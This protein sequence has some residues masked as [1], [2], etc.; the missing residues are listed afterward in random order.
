VDVGALVDA[1]L[2]LS[3]FDLFHGLA[4]FGG[5]GSGF[6]VRH[7]AS[8]SEDPTELADHPHHVGS[9]DD[10]VEVEEVL[11][12]DAVG[13]VLSAHDVGAGLLRLLRGFTGCERGDADALA[14]AV[15][16]RDRAPDH[17]VGLSRI[18][19]EP[20][21]HVDGFV[22]LALGG[23]FDQRDGFRRRIDL[24]ALDGLGCFGV[25]LPC[26]DCLLWSA[27]GAPASHA[28]EVL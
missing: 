3:G 12:L 15:R 16:Q 1:V 6:G 10:G 21:R 19:A 17:L 18:D 8:R 26:H 22:E 11:V 9:G 27:A 25:L 14:G 28:I 5:D 23:A 24:V 13:E 2:E 4:D 7:Q 20:D